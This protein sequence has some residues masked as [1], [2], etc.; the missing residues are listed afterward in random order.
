MA[1]THNEPTKESDDGWLLSKVQ[2][3]EGAWWIVAVS[4]FAIPLVI[5]PFAKDIFRFPKEMIFRASAIVL[6]SLFGLRWI[7]SRLSLGRIAFR[8]S[9]VLIPLAIVGWTVITTITSTNRRLSEESLITV[10][11][12][13][14]FF[15]GSRLAIQ[16]NP[17]MRALDVVLPA[18]VINAML[19]IA[20]EFRLWQPFTFPV[21]W[22][23]HMTT[24][25]LLGNPNDVAMFILPVTI[26]CFVAMSVFSGL[27]K[28]AYLIVFLILL[29]AL[30]A[31]GTRGAIVALGVGVL[32][33]A[34]RLSRRNAGLLAFSLLL[35]IG[36]AVSDSKLRGRFTG[37]VDASRNR[38][39]DILFSQRLPAFLTAIEMTRDHPVTGV[40]PGAYK[41]KYMEYKIALAAKY[42]E[43]WTRGWPALFRE[44]HNDH[45]QI[46]AETGV[47]GYTLFVLA[48][49]AMLFGLRRGQTPASANDNS[50]Q[51]FVGHL[52][53]PLGLSLVVVML[54]QFPL[55]IAAP[56]VVI[57][58]FCA[59]CTWRG[60][61]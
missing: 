40:G 29:L 58:Y 31:C 46:L 39:F 60:D 13:V 32:A 5:D 36:I 23:G 30:L 12:S 1:R 54:A 56:R 24:T 55:Q 34:V 8:D 51:T 11:C 53:V 3:S 61:R 50:F 20:Q 27:R 18:A 15:F 45:L 9:A 14:I 35:F 33:S 10:I 17:S 43:L 22:S 44:T 26:A 25:A 47:P 19:A 59:L 37:L 4:L 28:G 7:S 2:A 42:P 57:L 16:G 41:W 21:E 49:G 48:A 38:R 52:R 6:A